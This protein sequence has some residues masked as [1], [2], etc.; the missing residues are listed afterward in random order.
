ME[1]GFLLILIHPQKNKYELF[2][3]VFKDKPAKV[4]RIT[5]K[6]PKIDFSIE[7]EVMIDFSSKRQRQKHLV[8][9][10]SRAKRL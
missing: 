9:P 1:L 8:D 3:K 2:S 10:R 6:T 7:H 5:P 4:S